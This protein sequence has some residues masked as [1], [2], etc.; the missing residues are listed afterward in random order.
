MLPM[1]SLGN[2]VGHA[3]LQLNIDR[4][5]G[6]SDI[7]FQTRNTKIF[8]TALLS[9][10][11]GVL[12]LQSLGSAPPVADAFSLSNYYRLEPV[13]SVIA[14]D[15]QQFRSRWSRISIVYS[16][17]KAGDIDQLCSLWGLTNHQEFNFHFV[18]CN[19]FGGADGLIQPTQK[20]NRQWSVTPIPSAGI[21]QRTI[22][23]CVIADGTKI[24]PTELQ[25]KRTEELVEGL[26]R[27]FSIT[28]QSIRYPQN[29]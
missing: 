16:G 13:Q 5:Y 29:W 18:V 3:A 2:R 25:R 6:T 19:G 22:R 12:I 1:I 23:I 7:M 4:D 9:I 14:S 15:A 28:P 11:A 10:L 26:S 20:W 27:K 17:T 21:G 8:I 24:L